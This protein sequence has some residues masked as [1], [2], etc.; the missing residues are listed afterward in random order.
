M[1]V[2]A[3]EIAAVAAALALACGAAGPAGS[4][5]AE[6][7]RPDS[8]RSDSA[9]SDPAAVPIAG[10]WLVEAGTAVVR[11]AP[12]AEGPGYCGTLFPLAAGDHDPA[13]C[14]HRLIEGLQPVDRVVDQ[15]GDRS[16]DSRA[17]EAQ[18]AELPAELPAEL[19][20]EL[21]AEIPADSQT[22]SGT[23]A[24]SD[25]GAEPGDASGAA[26][27]R[28]AADANARVWDGATL[29]DP[30]NG[31]RYTASVE[32]TPEATPES[33]LIMRGYL[34]HPALGRSQL[35]TRYD[36]DAAALCTPPD[37]R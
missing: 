21:A 18:A 2:R 17:G 10:D 9:R 36:G 20:A 31:R 27:H 28:S 30:R 25:A 7:A 26:S 12:C 8:A 5:L 22:E 32:A 14:G 13:H 3:F 34:L 19:A 6:S 37:A 23:D 33:G 16:A 24:G 35:W 11:I 4:A 1:V 29:V 15:A